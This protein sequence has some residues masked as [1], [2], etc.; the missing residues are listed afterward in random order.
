MN[1]F[2][3][4]EQ[5]Q[6]CEVAPRDGF[7]AEKKWIPTEE[8]INL[9]HR[10][11]QAGVTSM[12][13]TSFVHPLAIPQLKDAEQVVAA[14]R[15]L[16]GLALRALIPNI[17]G[18]ERAFQ[19]GIKEVKC[20]LSATDAHSLANTNCTVDQALVRIQSIADYAQSKG[21]KA[22]GSI[23]VA[24]GCPY[25]GEVS[26]QQVER[27]ILSY[28][29][30]GIQE[31]SLADTTG[32]ANPRQVFD[33]FGKIRDRF[34]DVTFSAHFHNTRGLAQANVLAALQ[35]GI[36]EFDSSAAG[37]GGCPYAPGASGNVAS[38]DLVFMF[39]EMGI[40]TGIRINDLLLAAQEMK[41]VV[42]HD[43]GS[44]LLKAGVPKKHEQPAGQ[45]KEEKS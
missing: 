32:M 27:L 12:E 15:H 19:A 21:I 4:P 14:V 41:K 13:V 31:I 28:T 17:R 6:L 10:L 45:T 16:P 35:Q 18:A 38:E 11:H 37:L 24:F 25:V 26:P 8:K 2:K 20:I 30:L 42:G 5:V 39:Q 43:G 29:R 3:L 33:L 40:A 44:F 1:E 36:V 23:S 34:P 7:Q 22:T 9:I